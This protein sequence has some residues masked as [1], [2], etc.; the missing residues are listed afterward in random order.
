MEL[1]QQT[2]PFDRDDWLFEVK[3]DGFRSIA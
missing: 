2:S 1:V 3:Y